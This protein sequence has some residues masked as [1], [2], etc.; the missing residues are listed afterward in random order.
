MPARDSPASSL[1]RLLWEPGAQP[2]GKRRA[3]LSVARIVDAAV[4]LADAHGLDAV[5]M[6]RVAERLGFSPMALYRHVA[7]K[8]DLVVLMVNRALAPP[9]AP[10]P[11]PAG[12]WRTELEQWAWD[13]LATLRRHPWVLSVPIAGPPTTP[14][15]L[16]WLDR[17]LRALANTA[18]TE[19]EKAATILLLNGH[20]FWGA[21]LIVEL[22]RATAAHDDP[23]TP[24]PV[25][26]DSVADPDRYPALRQALDHGIFA[27]ASTEDD[28]IFGLQR[29]LDGIEH[30]LATR[31]HSRNRP[32][33]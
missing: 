11:R 16:D 9:D 17:G 8:D 27:E 19:P 23:V 13:V 4:D 33:R 7:A 32:S 22:D 29:I 3:P 2:R 25:P 30:H 18:L 12:D 5:S 15:Q 20:V 14:S 24:S 31:A 10:A 26:L 28:F 1:Q 21:R 6:N